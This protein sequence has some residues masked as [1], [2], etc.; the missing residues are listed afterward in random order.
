MN[1][2]SK[3][4]VI[5]EQEIAMIFRAIGY[6][7]FYDTDPAAVVARCQA[8]TKQD[9]KIILILEKQA[10]QI[11]DYLNSRESIAYP[12]I[13]P[14]PDTVTNNNY[15]LQRLSRNMEKAMGRKLG[16]NL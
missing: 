14:I 13:M 10:A 6:D 7:C 15:G 1:N 4:A 11:E 5:G 3:I 9:Y 2:S 12:I 16:G 8:L